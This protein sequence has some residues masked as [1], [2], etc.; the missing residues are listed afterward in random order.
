MP[1]MG[2]DHQGATPDMENRTRPI[3]ALPSNV[4]TLSQ[5]GTDARASAG[6]TRQC[7]KSK[8]RQV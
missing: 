7:R 5:S 2:G 6:E 1:G 8:F 3:Q 4:S